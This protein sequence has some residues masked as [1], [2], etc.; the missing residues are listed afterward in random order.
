MRVFAF[1]LVTEVLLLYALT[2]KTEPIF[3]S[4][5]RS[6]QNQ[7]LELTQIFSRSIKKAHF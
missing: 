1:A 3:P 2:S 6:F 5:A 4:H 7:D